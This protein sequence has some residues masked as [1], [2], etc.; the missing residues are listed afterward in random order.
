MLLL[1]RWDWTDRLLHRHNNRLSAAAVGGRGG[2]AE[3]HLPAAGWQVKTQ[4]CVKQK[5]SECF[6]VLI[7]PGLSACACA[8]VVW[9]R[10][11]S[12]TSSSI[13]PWACTMPVSLQKP[14]SERPSLQGDAALFLW[15]VNRKKAG[16]GSEIWD[17]SE[18]RW[19]SQTTNEKCCGSYLL[20]KEKR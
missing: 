13:T 20:K 1:Q 9:S 17:F 10:Q 6:S 7:P 2:C 12:S 8:E 18:M 15:C 3:H 16:G 11:V 14:V 4:R 19:L 5:C